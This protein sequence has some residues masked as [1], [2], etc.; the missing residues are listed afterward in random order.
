M[1]HAKTAQI[2][3]SVTLSCVSNCFYF[4][5]WSRS[6]GR[7]AKTYE[8]RSF[9]GIFSRLCPFSQ[10]FLQVKEWL[11]LELHD[12]IKA[13]HVVTFPVLFVLFCDQN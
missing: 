2:H 13:S 5:L 11:M 9:L 4:A 3:K 6:A 7:S 1:S 8:Q 10:V 12:M